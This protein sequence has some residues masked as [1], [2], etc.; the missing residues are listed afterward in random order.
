MSFTT[1][2]ATQ[3]SDIETRR[4]CNELIFLVDSDVE[5]APNAH[6]TLNSYL[7]KSLTEDK[8]FYSADELKFLIDL[9]QQLSNKIENEKQLIAT[10]IISKQKSKNAVKKYKSHF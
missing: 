8:S 5:Q 3:I 7:K 4:Q 6:H 2:T 1:V 9:I 10:K